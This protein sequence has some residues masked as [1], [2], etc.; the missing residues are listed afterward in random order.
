MALN[1]R[2]LAPANASNTRGLW[3]ATK[4]NEK[5]LGHPAKAA[6]RLK[7]TIVR[8]G[9]IQELIDGDFTEELAATLVARG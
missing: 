8:C 9:R 5:G 1:I 2:R 3:R 6:G 4:T 7:V